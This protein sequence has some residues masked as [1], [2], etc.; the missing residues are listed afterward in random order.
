VTKT[1]TLLGVSRKGYVGM[2]ES[3]E[4]NISEEEQLAKSNTG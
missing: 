4:D 2:H 1:V 3:L